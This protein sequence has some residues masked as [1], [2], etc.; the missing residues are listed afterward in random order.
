MNEKLI[1]ELLGP[2]VKYLWKTSKS[3]IVFGFSPWSMTFCLRNKKKY[4]EY[5]QAF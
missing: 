2:F 4:F 1:V 5:F 3:L